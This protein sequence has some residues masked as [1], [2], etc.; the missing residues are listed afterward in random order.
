MAKMSNHLERLPTELLSA[1]FRMLTKSPI[2]SVRLVS[3]RCNAIASEYL[4]QSI[5]FAFRH[6]TLKGLEAISQHPIFSRTVRNLVYDVSI[7]DEMIAESREAY[8]QWLVT[9][10]ESKRPWSRTAGSWRTEDRERRLLYWRGDS[11]KMETMMMIRWIRKEKR[12]LN[13]GWNLYRRYFVEQE[14][15]RNNRSYMQIL[16]SSL[17]RMKNLTNLKF[18]DTWPTSTKYSEVWTKGYQREDWLEF[19]LDPQPPMWAEGYSVGISDVCQVWRESGLPLQTIS[20]RGGEAA[21]EILFLDGSDILPNGLHRVKELELVLVTPRDYPNV[22]VHGH[23]PTADTTNILECGGLTLFQG[24]RR[25][26]LHFSRSGARDIDTYFGAHVPPGRML[27]L[28][29]RSQLKTL[30]L[31][32][33]DMHLRELERLILHL[34]NTLISLTLEE[35]TLIS[36]SWTHALDSLGTMKKLKSARLVDMYEH[37]NNAIQTLRWY[38]HDDPA[39]LI[40]RIEKYVLRGGLNPLTNGRIWGRRYGNGAFVLRGPGDIHDPSWICPS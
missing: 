22:P 39:Y 9:L 1:I 13:R 7:Y 6:D 4:M 3:R 15:I 2:K 38:S 34:R 24:L 37:F 8:R 32:N 20:A 25:L 14:H 33:F 23:N 16:K 26:D 31:R 29:I 12:D 21:F 36:G 11:K 35:V 30:R 18:V 17:S 19:C 27:N 28:S 5:T 40:E 10:L